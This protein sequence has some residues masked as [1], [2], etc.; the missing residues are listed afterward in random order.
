MKKHASAY[1]RLIISFLTAFLL[2]LSPSN[3]NGQ[4]M[5]TRVQPSLPEGWVEQPYIENATEPVL[6]NKE[7]KRGFMLFSRPVTEP[8]Y[9]NTRPLPH[10][11]LYLLKAFATQGE[12][13]PLTFTVYPVKDIKG[14][15]VTVTSLRNGKNVI[16]PSNLDLRLVTCWN[17]HYPYWISQGSYRN[18]PELLEKVTIND[19]KKGECQRYWIIVHVPE[20]TKAGIYDGLV[21]I[22][23]EGLEREVEIPVKFRVLGFQ[24][25]KDPRKHFTAYF[26]P[27]EEQY[28]GM[29]GDLYETAVTNELQSMLNYGIDIIPTVYTGGDGDHITLSEKRKQLI[30]KML[31]MGF[32]GPVPVYSGSSIQSL[33]LKHEGIKYKSHWKIDKLPSDNFYETVTRAFTEFR[34]MWEENGWP[35]MYVCPIDE[36]DPTVR[37][38]GVRVYKAVR[39]AG[40]K[41]Y[42]TKE[43]TNNDAV[44]Y[45]PYVNAWCS[46]PYDVSYKTATSGDHEYWC[47]PNHNAGEKRNRT[48]MFKG[49]R[50]TYGFGFWRS[51]Y[52]LLIPWH[53]RW[54]TSAGQFEYIRPFATPFGMRMDEKGNIIPAINWECFREGYD[55]QRYIYTL[56]QA[57][58]EHRGSEDCAGLVSESEKFLQDIW[59]SIKVRPLYLKTDMWPSEEFNMIRW[60][61]AVY[62]SKLL[63]CPSDTDITAPSVLKSIEVLQ[64]DEN[65]E[66]YKLIEQMLKENMFEV[67]DLGSNDFSGWVSGAKEGSISLTGNGGKDHTVSLKYTVVVDQEKDGTEENGKYPVGWPG[68]SIGFKKGEI[69]LPEYDYLFFYVNVSPDRNNTI[70]N[71]PFFI[72]INMYDKKLNTEITINPDREHQGIPVV[73]S[74]PK[75]IAASYYD[76]KFWKYLQNISIGIAERWYEDKTKL[77]FNFDKIFLLKSRE[78]IIN[79]IEVQDY[80]DN[81]QKWIQINLWGLGFGN[82][83]GKGYRI[84]LIL[85]GP[86]GKEIVTTEKSLEDG[87]SAIMNISKINK[88]GTYKI[89]AGILD[90]DGKKVSG[91]EKSIQVISGCIQ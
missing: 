53:W 29:E 22:S 51:G 13:E 1:C 18:V 37:E 12:F 54:I 56:E 68:I 24:L 4:E 79:E 87:L 61:M 77:S 71:T 41:T 27:P 11:R 9:K 6:T 17:T 74:V 25:Q 45:G 21:N 59:K 50:M 49:G 84:E 43:P 34:E 7:I 65:N 58:E 57:I 78:P 90:K 48:I 70:I 89:N 83:R 26:G 23:C 66:K 8:V 16:D 30:N 35:E 20:N 33:M 85:E 36:V 72:S 32:T 31:E 5:R 63:A 67:L 42:I 64:T 19:V 86:N 2:G 52:S 73:V 62:L 60:K 39:D 88:T 38:F 76:Q 14:L 55:D 75:L 10:E 40:I 82:A 69:D 91:L 46:Q 80:V 81:S 44:Q 15:R 47:Y 28:R 3:V